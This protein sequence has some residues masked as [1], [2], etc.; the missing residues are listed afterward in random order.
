M[1]RPERAVAAAEAAR[2]AARVARRRAGEPLAYLLGYREFYSLRLT[3]GPAVLVPRPETEHLVDWALECLSGALK[4][5]A[6]PRVIDLGT[7]SGAIALAVAAASPAARVVA[8]DRSAAALAI[9]RRNGA[10]L[11]LAVEWREGDWWHAPGQPSRAGQGADA[12]FHLALANPPYVAAGDPHLAALAHEPTSALV[13][14]ADGLDALRLIVDGA[15]AWMAAGGWLLME[16]G[17]EQG[18][19]VRAMLAAQG[20]TPVS[21]RNDLAGQPRCSGGRWPG[22]TASAAAAGDVQNGR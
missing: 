1:A 6:A 17:H 19:A 16:H 5:V 14:G 18:P 9:A 22:A 4:G 12:P 21:T 2:F 7:G 11:G 13:A 15:P 8:V 10:R 3:V 20:F